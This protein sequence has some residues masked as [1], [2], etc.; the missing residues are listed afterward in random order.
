MMLTDVDSR[1]PKF[2]EFDLQ[3][4]CAQLVETL[5]E[6]QS[7]E[8]PPT[9][10]W[11]NLPKVWGDPDMIFQALLNLIGNGLKYSKKDVGPTV[12][13]D[14]NK[15]SE[16]CEIQVNDLGLGIASNKLEE[17]VEPF[18]RLWSESEFKG[19]GLGLTICHKIAEIHG[20]SLKIH[21]VE[22][23]GSSFSIFLPV[24]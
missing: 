2:V 13:I 12:W 9:V 22:N 15:G 4:V 5:L 19:S 10:K 17:V 11:G 6:G 14:V 21:S 7:F 18:K 3:N 23:E 24:K 20:G 8:N 1:K 16:Y